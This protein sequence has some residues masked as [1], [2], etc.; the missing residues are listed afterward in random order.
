MPPMRCV[1]IRY[2][3][4][5]TAERALEDVRHERGKGKGRRGKAERRIYWHKQ[6]DAFHLT[7]MKKAQP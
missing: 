6:C 2:F 5:E 4:L 3:D 7:S 1:K